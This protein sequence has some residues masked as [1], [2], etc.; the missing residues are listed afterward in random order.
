MHTVKLSEIKD[1][2]WRVLSVRRNDGTEI[3]GWD[4]MNQ[5]RMDQDLGLAFEVFPEDEHV[6]DFANMRHLI[7]PPDNFDAPWPELAIMGI[8][9]TNELRGIENE[10]GI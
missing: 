5:I 10:G 8:V 1:S 6:I 2:G 7:I 9:E 4:E 3:Q